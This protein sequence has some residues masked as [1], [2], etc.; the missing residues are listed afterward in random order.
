MFWLLSTREMD[1]H[2]TSLYD[3]AGVF[4]AKSTGTFCWLTYWWFGLVGNRV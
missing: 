3:E 4:I 2:I 1:K